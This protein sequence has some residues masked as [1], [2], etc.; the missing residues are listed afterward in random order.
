MTEKMI[1]K[2]PKGKLIRGHLPAFKQ[3]PLAFL[4]KIRKE[5]DDMAKI[6]FAHQTIYHILDANLIKEILIT[7]ASSF[8]KARAFKQI[9]PFVGEGLLTSEGDFHK[10]QRRIMQPPFTQH[11]IQS[12]APTMSVLAKSLVGN[13]EDGETR[14]IH[15]DMMNTALAIICKTM[16]SMDVYETHDTVG[17]SIDTAMFVATKRIR[18]TIKIP[19]V[20]PTKENLQFENA[21]KTLDDVIGK[22][23]QHRKQHPEIEHDDLLSILMNTRDSEGNPVLSSQQL[24]DELMTIFLAGHETTANAMVW[25]IYLIAQH[26]EV[27]ERVTKEVDD[28]IGGEPVSLEH[29]ERLSY[30]KAVIQEAIRLYP[31]AWMFGREAKEKVTLFNGVALK[32]GDIVHISPYLLHRSERYYKDATSFNPDRFLNDSL[33]NLP[34]FAYL[35]FGGG[36]R[37]CIGN[38][39]AMQEALIVLATMYQKVT[40]QL[41]PDHPVEP[42]PLIT[43]R[44]KHGLK[45]MVKERPGGV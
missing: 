18:S 7:Q 1:V 20:I 26:P 23:I 40:L 2:G 45:V 37:V 3:D 44:P 43:L 13:W 12:Y 5:H 11:H 9:K 4:D 36:A 6:R 34:R 41:K 24:R 25:T 8:Q 21:V 38:H 16:F 19:S 39:F 30:L 31:P 17:E 32:K 33:K 29:I 42:E 28:E 27:E 15:V 22:I 10:Q 35:P 14:D